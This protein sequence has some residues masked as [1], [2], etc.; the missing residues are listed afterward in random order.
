M[1]SLPYTLDIPT[2]IDN[3][4]KEETRVR[5]RLVCKRKGYEWY[6]IDDWVQ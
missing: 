1:Q 5:T 3:Y 6:M 4:V 2:S